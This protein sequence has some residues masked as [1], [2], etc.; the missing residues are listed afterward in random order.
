MAT[1]PQARKVF[2]VGKIRPRR[3]DG[4]KPCTNAHHHGP[5]VRRMDQDLETLYAELGLPSD[6]L[7]PQYD[8]LA[9]GSTRGFTPRQLRGAA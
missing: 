2:R 3:N 1:Q 8:C 7:L 6:G 9:C 5:F 4:S